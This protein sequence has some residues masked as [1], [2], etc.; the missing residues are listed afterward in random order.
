MAKLDLPIELT[1][2][3]VDKCWKFAETAWE[4]ESQSQRQF[5]RT[6]KRTREEF[7]AD[8]V[9]GKLA[10]I[11]MQKLLAQL[12]LKIGLDFTHYLSP[13]DID[14]GDIAWIEVDG[15]RVKPTK[16][17]DVKGTGASSKWLLVEEYKYIS[18]LYLLMKIV[19]MPEKSVA[20]ANP[21]C[22][23]GRVFHAEPAGWAAKGDFLCPQSGRFWFLYQ[24]GEKLINPDCLPKAPPESKIA[25]RRYL[26]TVEMQTMNVELAAEINYGL[27][28]SWLCRDWEKLAEILL[29]S[30]ALK[31]G[32]AESPA[33]GKP[34]FSSSASGRKNILAQKIASTHPRHSLTILAGTAPIDSDV[35]TEIMR[36]LRRGV[37]VILAGRG[38]APTADAEEFLRAGLLQVY[39]P[40]E[41]SMLPAEPV[42]IVDGLTRTPAEAGL[43]ENLETGWKP[44]WK[45][46][47]TF[48]YSQFTVEHAPP[49]DHLCVRA[50]AGA[51]KTTVMVQRV[52]FL[53]HVVPDLHP[54]EIVMITFTRDA[55]HEM[56]TR[57]QRELITRYRLA[58]DRREWYRELLEKLNEM[59]IKTI[60]AFARRILLAVGAKEGFG[61]NVSLREFRLE[62][63]RILEDVVSARA[64]LSKEIEDQLGAPVYKF[65]QA[66]D[67]YWQEM[68]RKGLT[69][70]E[71][72]SLDWG[73]AGSK[74]E[75][76]QE[77][78]RELFPE[79]ERRLTKLKK[80]LN[81]ISLQDLNR[82]LNGMRGS[83]VELQRRLGSAVRF[84]FVDE[85]Q[86]TDDSQI[87]LVLWLQEALRPRPA[88]F[89]V[90]DVKQSIY[91][92]RGANATAFDV[93]VQGAASQGCR[94]R[95][96]TLSRNYRTD[97][98]LL[99]DMHPVFTAWSKRRWLNY[100][101]ESDRLVGDRPGGRKI[102]WV[103][104]SKKLHELRDDVVSLIRAGLSQL[105]TDDSGN[106]P[107][108][109][110]AVL[111][112]T[113]KH[114]R[115]IKEWCD[116]EGIFCHVET[117]GD[118]YTTP[119][120]VD[121]LHLVGALLFP[122][123]PK[124]L[125]NLYSGPYS[126]VAVPWQGIVG[127]GGCPRDILEHLQAQ[128]PFDGWE[129]YL[130]DLRLRPV[131]SVIRD[132]I[133]VTDPGQRVY[134]R[135]RDELIATGVER[136]NAEQV[137]EA[138]AAQYVRNLNK[139]MEILQD[140]FAIDSV[141]LHSIYEFLQL[142]RAVD[143]NED[144][145]P[146]SEEE[147]HAAVV[148]K[149]VHKA[150]GQ[151]FHTVIVPFTTNRFN[152]SRSELLLRWDVDRRRWRAGWALEV[153]KKKFG[154]DLLTND[155]YLTIREDEDLEVQREETRL[156][157]VAM[158]RAKS[159]LVIIRH[160]WD[161]DCWSELLRMR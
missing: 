64:D 7:L 128:P 84:L 1:R 100:N 124:A 55:A 108:E 86:D 85:F 102:E 112:R 14:D 61:T 70:D 60:H 75:P 142:K 121:L 32:G 98:V 99:D 87:R 73:P 37:K 18:D 92:F 13:G 34:L 96:I 138:E 115:I 25:L 52:L 15:N 5:G 16:R 33:S 152:W 53:L 141:T 147:K 135:K 130:D 46:G 101:P 44:A 145:A 22:L 132:I 58:V 67:A 27:P 127:Y 74:A 107:R 69:L 3:E 41:K 149:T 155:N 30:A 66:A 154:V 38:A 156:L 72:S 117:G 68:E 20:R 49:D 114:A 97:R 17:L 89:V 140:T 81:A 65:I 122:K 36:L 10:E 153:Q 137:A 136:S 76:I 80:Q 158:T 104:T 63:Q 71:I 21:E 83:T 139:M 6:V 57:L 19:D 56:R 103:D 157:Y 159:R 90:G 12:G 110:V 95:D 59:P 47:R 129:G 143:R 88:L 51:G 151:E 150:K 54:K 131:L 113:N 35:S 50:G 79:A 119:A 91:R 11:A 29:E 24:S 42:L 39:Q 105:K 48:N 126:R 26:Q 118:F 77:I 160:P 146:P 120:V 123:D 62:R 78:L 4:A 23:R 94:F 40:T 8:Q 2:L 28:V 43:I 109:Q 106:S 144:Q 111:V 125:L 45:S 82:W 93:L 148:C 116:Q 31:P 134:Q 133:K 9:E 161:S